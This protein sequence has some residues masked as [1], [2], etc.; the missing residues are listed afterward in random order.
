MTLKT[1]VMIQKIQLFC[2]HRNKIEKL[3]LIIIIFN[4]ITAFTVF[5]IK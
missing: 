2:H 1:G 3:F 4:N 5:L